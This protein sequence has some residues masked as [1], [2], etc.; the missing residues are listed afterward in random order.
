[1]PITLEVTKKLWT[2]GF[3]LVK[4]RIDCPVLTSKALEE[5]AG[6]LG[7]RE[8]LSVPIAVQ[9]RT[10][11]LRTTQQQITKPAAKGKK[12]STKKGPVGQK[13]LG[14]F[15][16]K[17]KSCNRTKPPGKVKSISTPKKQRVAAAC[18]VEPPEGETSFGV[19]TECPAPTTAQSGA[20]KTYRCEEVGINVG[21]VDCQVGNQPNWHSIKCLSW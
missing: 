10:T 20:D 9:S 1:M 7:R 11:W 4:K 18:P 21:Q 6:K 16:T 2:T 17:T 5:V 3:L 15:L 14:K 13:P 8:R 12:S 19:D